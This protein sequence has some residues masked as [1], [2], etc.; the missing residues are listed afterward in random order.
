MP[1][2]RGVRWLGVLYLTVMMGWSPVAPPEHVHESDDD[3]GVHH[4]LVH[5]HA[6]GHFEGSHAADHAELGESE[7]Q[8][9]TLDAAFMLPPSPVHSVPV[10]TAAI[11]LDEPTVP[12]TR[13]V[14]AD[15]VELLIHGPP[16]APT[17]L[18]APPSASRL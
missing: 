17:G 5:W 4:L 1:A 3:H 7:S 16:R 10:S 6:E 2:M 9:L 8:T 11:V 18:R 13:R 14:V 15:D 12:A